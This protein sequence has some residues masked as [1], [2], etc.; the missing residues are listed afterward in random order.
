LLLLALTWF[1]R[2]EHGLLI[3]TIRTITPP[4][5]FFIDLFLNGCTGCWS[6]KLTFVLLV[7]SIFR[8]LSNIFSFTAATSA[9]N[10]NSSLD[11]DE[12]IFQ[13]S[14]VTFHFPGFEQVLE[15][16]LFRFALF[17]SCNYSTISPIRFF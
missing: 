17:R 6:F 14:L 2:T 3:L 5:R 11:T 15:V 13:A 9:I 1:V 8:L 4:K 16:C 12:V 10:F 7:V